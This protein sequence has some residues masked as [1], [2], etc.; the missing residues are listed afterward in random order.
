MVGRTIISLIAT[1]DGC[2]MANET[3]QAMLADSIPILLTSTIS[4]FNF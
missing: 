4:D 3:E 1:S 2:S